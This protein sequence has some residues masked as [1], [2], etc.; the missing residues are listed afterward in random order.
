[1]KVREFTL[2]RK[3]LAT[4]SIIVGPDKDLWF[5]EFRGFGRMTVDGQLSEA[6]CTTAN[7]IP[8]P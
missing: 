4:Y 8:A 7:R 6:I 3:H 2:P 1:V 5:T